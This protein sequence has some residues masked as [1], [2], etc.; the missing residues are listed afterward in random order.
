MYIWISTLVKGLN[1]GGKPTNLK[2]VKYHKCFKM[3]MCSLKNQRWIVAQPTWTLTM[4]KFKHFFL[5]ST[6]PTT[7]WI[8]ECNGISTCPKF[9]HGQ[10][11]MLTQSCSVTCHLLVVQRR[12]CG[13]DMSLL[14]VIYDMVAQISGESWL[15][16]GDHMDVI[17]IHTIPWLEN[18]NSNDETYSYD[19]KSKC[20]L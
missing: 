16:K 14:I 20:K 18:N 2:F 11:S 4:L 8:G 12:W 6:N 17:Y 10:P 3:D 7:E 9:N 13:N 5:Y 19:H 15:V 1:Y